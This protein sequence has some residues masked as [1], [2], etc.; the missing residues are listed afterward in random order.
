VVLGNISLAHLRQA[1]T[2]QSLWFELPN[3]F[4][5]RFDIIRKTQ[6]YSNSYHT[7]PHSQCCQATSYRALTASSQRC[8][9]ANSSNPPSPTT[10]SPELNS[11]FG[12]AILHGISIRFRPLPHICSILVQRRENSLQSNKSAD[13]LKQISRLR[14]KLAALLKQLT[15]YNLSSAAIKC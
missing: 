6:H 4:V 13:R 2:F 5:K 1:R 10:D 15:F 3:L 12:V 14:T 9:T 11:A 7:V 8:G